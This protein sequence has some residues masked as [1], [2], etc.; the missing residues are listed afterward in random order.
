MLCD[1]LTLIVLCVLCLSVTLIMHFGLTLFQTGQ[2]YRMPLILHL[3]GRR[4]G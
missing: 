2:A 1:E 3:D 4:L